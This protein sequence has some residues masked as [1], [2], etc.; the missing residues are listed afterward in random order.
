MSCIVSVNRSA[1]S[2]H[3]KLIE[4]NEEPIV[5]EDPVKCNSPQGNNCFP[6]GTRFQSNVLVTSFKE[7]VSFTGITGIPDTFANRS[8]LESI[9]VPSF[10][11][12]IG[13]EAFRYSSIKEFIIQ[14]GEKG[15]TFS[16]RVFYG[17]STIPFI[18]LPAR[19]TSIGSECFHTC[20][21][22]RTIIVRATTPPTLGSNAFRYLTTFDI[23]VPDSSVD[24]Y[25]AASYWSSLAS[26][27]K[28]L[29]EYED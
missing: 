11:T 16:N 27:I 26:H 7:I 9:I 24:A 23:Y 8:S 29:S 17:C 15:L 18:D 14:A 25:K 13:S 19:V 4:F 10:V 1:R 6:L 22:L 28:P 5:R 2:E 12:T 20:Y 3:S 21:A